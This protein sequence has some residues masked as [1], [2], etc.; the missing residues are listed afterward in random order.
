MF[1]Y[2][3]KATNALDSSV[4]VHFLQKVL[5]CGKG[6]VR[7]RVGNTQFSGAQTNLI[8]YQSA[9]NLKPQWDRLEKWREGAI[10]QE[11]AATWGPARRLTND[12]AVYH[13]DGV[14]ETAH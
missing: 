10:V 6:G 8:S 9:V 1:R 7:R 13:E 11:R 5:Q 14:K 2:S 4:A 3:R 12:R